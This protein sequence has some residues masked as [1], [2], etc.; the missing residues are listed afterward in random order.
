M[1]KDKSYNGAHGNKSKIKYKHNFKKNLLKGTAHS[2]NSFNFFER[3][4][5]SINFHFFYAQ[6]LSGKYKKQTHFAIKMLLF[7]TTFF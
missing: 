5:K 4:L 2:K 1:R 7:E 3:G 6:S